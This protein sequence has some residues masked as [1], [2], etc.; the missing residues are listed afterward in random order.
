MKRKHFWLQGM[1]RLLQEYV[2]GC[3]GNKRPDQTLQLFSE[4][5]VLEDLSLDRPGTAMYYGQA[6]EDHLQKVMSV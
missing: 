6:R 2:T 4:A 3:S 5:A 1:A